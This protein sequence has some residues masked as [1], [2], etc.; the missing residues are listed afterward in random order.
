MGIRLAGL[1]VQ[2]IRRELRLVEMVPASD[3]YAYCMPGFVQQGANPPPV[4]PEPTGEIIYLISET[5]DYPGDG[6]GRGMLGIPCLA[7]CQGDLIH[8]YIH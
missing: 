7:C 6:M 8:V 4:N 2:G 5:F 1:A 3:V